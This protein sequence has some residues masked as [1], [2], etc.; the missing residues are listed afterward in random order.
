MCSEVAS[1]QAE[2]WQAVQSSSRFRPTCRSV[3]IL[4]TEVVPRKAT[5]ILLRGPRAVQASS[6][7]VSLSDSCT[8]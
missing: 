2:L 5:M 4:A 7:L 3:L 1:G 8:A 6:T